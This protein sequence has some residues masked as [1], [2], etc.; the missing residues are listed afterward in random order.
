LQGTNTGNNTISGIIVNNSTANPT[1]VTKTDTGTWTLTAGNAYSGNT[2]LNTAGKLNIGNQFALGFSKFIIAQNGFFDNTSGADMTITNTF[3]LS[4]GSP[5]YVGSANN[6]TIT[7]PV[8]ISGA[9]RTITV[10]ARTLTLTS[11]INQDQARNFTKAGP[12][13]LVLAGGSAHTGSLIINGGTL[14]IGG[15][16]Q[17]GGG[18]Y[19]ATI[20]NTNGGTLNY[21]SS[22]AQTLSGVF[23]G[24]G[25][26]VQN[27][28]GTLTL[29]AAN[30]YSGPSTVASGTLD[31]SA[32]GSL[33]ASPVAVASGATLQ[34]DAS[35]ALG[36]AVNLLL[37]SGTPVV[38][39]NYVGTDQIQLLS[40]DGGATFAPGGT[41]GAIGSGATF[42]DARFTG[43]GLLAVLSQPTTGVSPSANPATYGDSVTL[44]ASV[45][46]AGPT[47]TGTVTFKEGATT[48]GTQPLDGT[49]SAA[50]ST[51]GFSAATHSITVVYGGDVNYAPSTSPILALVVSKAPLNV[52]ANN[53]TKVYGQT[54]TFGSG[55]TAFSSTG[56]KLSDTIGTVT[57]ACAGGVATAPVSGSPYSITP[58]AATGGNFNANNYTITY[59]NGNLTVTPATLTVTATGRLIYGSDPSNAVYF[60]KY[61]TLQGT[62]T[63]AVISGS[64]D[65]STDATSSNYVGSNY[66]AH[67]VD[68]GTLSSPNY[69]FAAGADGVL[70]I[71]NRP[72]TVTNVLAN[73][74]VYD[75]TTAATLDLTGAGLDNLVN[76]DAVTLVTSTATGSFDD[77]NVGVG[78]TV[79][80]TGLTTAGD[81]G[82]NYFLIQPTATA[83]IS[84]LSVT[85]TA[86]AD[87]KTYD[88]TTTSA[89]TPIASPPIAPGDIASFS[90]VFDTKNAGTGKTLSASGFVD[91]SND[92]VNYALTFAS[93]TTGVISPKNITVTAVTD[94]K[95]YDGTR[96]SAGIPNISPA[97]ITGDTSGFSQIFDN[98][99]AG[100]GKTLIPQGSASDGNSGL[101][102]AVSFVNDTTGVITAQAI[103]VTAVSDSKVYDGTINSTASPT[104]APALL[105]GDTSEFSEAYDSRNVGIG[106]TLIP[107]GQARDGNGGANYS[108]TLVNDTTGA[109]TQMPITVTAV[110]TT[111]VYDGTTSSSGNPTIAPSLAVGD[112]SSFIQTYDT[113]DFGN[114][115]TLIPSGTVL[116]GNSG[117]NYTIAFFNNSNGVITQLSTTNLLVSSA[118]PSILGDDVTFT[119]TINGNPPAADLPT[120]AVVFFDAHGPFATNQL[121]NGSCSASSSTLPV[122]TNLISAFYFGDNNG[123]DN[124]GQSGGTLNQ[125]VTNSVIYSA[126]NIILSISDNNNGTVTLNLL[127]TPGAEYYL[128]S[129]SDLKLPLSSWPIL[130]GSTNTASSPSGLWSQVVGMTNSS[131]FF[132]SVAINPAP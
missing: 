128:V 41:Y 46:G 40:F 3:T 87:T 54:V 92:G 10:S 64:A 15:S 131:A 6:M 14:T 78:K 77:R 124:F 85:V 12:G 7:G 47:P 39:L 88:G 110:A 107:S 65:F 22:A 55:S 56:L 32:S 5:T 130:G 74:K 76:G 25:A 98:K 35:T 91:D 69:V 97:L 95:G 111:N 122:G 103:T 21:S 24:T 102:Y 120:G 26:L 61:D 121:V 44:T 8:T 86:V 81:L 38:N 96:N 115:K 2:T 132:R 80:V 43:T 114:G 67:V 37:N 59:N 11:T 83:N 29:S 104:I 75:G 116:D 52:T 73:N 72:L 66:I 28:P 90:Q 71:T 117:A 16:G 45:T 108:V 49:G 99:N 9:N 119:F 33:T 94:T 100:T 17:L 79:S 63:V 70:I 109:I 84:K 101:N 127:G 62:D 31:I 125:V 42:E 82:T 36:S 51:N 60:P 57:L 23:S 68:T 126:T 34:L 118:N 123:P 13:T 27:G 20:I 50:I 93:V 19:A 58:S 129:S 106:K 1:S 89:G 113:K 112:T 18:T 48:L 53:Q 105:A 4:G 30:T